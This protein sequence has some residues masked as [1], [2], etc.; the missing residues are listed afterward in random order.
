LTWPRVNE[1]VV[2]STCPLR[3]DL[4]VEDARSTV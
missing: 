4:P 1:T 3:E 2:T